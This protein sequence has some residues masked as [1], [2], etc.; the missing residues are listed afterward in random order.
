MFC[1]NCGE[2]LHEQSHFC[3]NCGKKVLNT[4]IANT[5]KSDNSDTNK[6]TSTEVEDRELPPTVIDQQTPVQ[7]ITVK[8]EVSEQP[9]QIIRSRFFKKLPILIPII[10][11]LLVGG[12]VSAS[13]F[14]EMNKNEEVLALQQSANDAALN[15]DYTTAEEKLERAQG[16]RPTY[17]ALQEDLDNVSRASHYKVRL[18]TISELIEEENFSKAKDRLTSL[19]KAVEAEEDPMFEG[20]AEQIT[21]TQAALTVGTIKQDLSK[22]TTIKQLANKL[23]ELSTQSSDE[24]AA[25][26]EQIRLKIV[27]ISKE[28]AETQLQN[29][30]FSDAIATVNQGLEYASGNKTLVSVKKKIEQEQAAFEQA[31]QERLEQARR[32]QEAFERAEQE[33]LEQEREA[34]AQ[35]D[36]I[37]RTAAVSIISLDTQLDESGDLYLY[38]DIKNV[39]TVDLTSIVIYYTVHDADGTYL[40]AGSTDVTPHYIG[41]G[42]QGSFEDVIHN[43]SVDANVQIDYISWQ[44]Y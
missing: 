33:R 36:L 24:A 18:T 31:E 37:N 2:Q 43:L 8:T 20:F 12:G 11:I 23:N 22:F 15:G 35:Q 27:Q 3:S 41:Q 21:L 17:A 28:N 7:P 38:G 29:N 44:F 19:K 26:K 39:A 6:A 25:V 16:I 42:E 13:Y 14:H 40:S 30:Q 5:E 4:R 9:K 34:A 32:E 10:S 1:H